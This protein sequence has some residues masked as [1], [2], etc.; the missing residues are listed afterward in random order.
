VPLP[1]P[2]LVAVIQITL[3]VAVQRHPVPA[4]TLM[5]AAPPLAGLEALVGETVNVH[6]AVPLCVT[7]TV[8]P[9]TVRVALRE[10]VEVLANTV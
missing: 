5:L 10:V 4:V 9:A 8:C 1:L 6:G 7:V 2:L 3:L